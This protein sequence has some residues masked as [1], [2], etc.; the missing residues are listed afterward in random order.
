MMKKSGMIVITMI[1]GCVQ[2][3]LAGLVFEADFDSTTPG[4]AWKAKLDNGTTIGSW[5]VG[6][7][8]SSRVTTNGTDAV[9]RMSGTTYDYTANFSQTFDVTG[10][11][12]SIAFDSRSIKAESAGA[13]INRIDLLNESGAAVLSF[14]Y[15]V[16][17]S[18]ATYSFNRADGTINNNNPG[19]TLLSALS[20]ED[21]NAAPADLDGFELKLNETSWGIYIN[22]S[23]VTNGL[24]YV[25]GADTVVSKLQFTTAGT[26]AGTGAFYDNITVIPEPATLGLVSCFGGMILWIRRYFTV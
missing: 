13:R 16:G 26:V 15:R 25:T 1:L 21:N 18:V 9:F 10:G 7:R 24:D 23:I 17:S 11:G 8:D 12:G 19:I 14:G 22:G 20:P 2:F 5:T 3:T 4:E 6:N